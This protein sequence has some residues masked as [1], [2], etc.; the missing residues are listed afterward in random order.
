MGEGPGLGSG[1]DG[2][3]VSGNW[4]LLVQG[5]GYK[6]I[7]QSLGLVLC[8]DW[9][10]PGLWRSPGTTKMQSG[11]SRETSDWT[12]G[13]VHVNIQENLHNFRT[14][15]SLFIPVQPDVTELDEI[16]SNLSGEKIGQYGNFPLK[17]NKKQSLLN[18][19]YTLWG[20]WVSGYINQ[21]HRFQ[22][23]TSWLLLLLPGSST[24]DTLFHKLV[25]FPLLST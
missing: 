3:T 8:W 15:R 23:V 9:T 6:H 4:E 21:N 19:S 16:R 5:Q 20:D 24:L 10:L 12:D 1:K 14:I 18:I 2:L 25:K 7:K 22:L 17:S 11:L 13:F